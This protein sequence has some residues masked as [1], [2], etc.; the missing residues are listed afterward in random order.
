[1]PYIKDDIGVSPRYVYKLTSRY[2]D[3]ARCTQV[4]NN[5]KRLGIHYEKREFG[6]ICA[7]HFGDSYERHVDSINPLCYT[8]P[9][10]YM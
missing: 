5:L 1:M 10:C 6:S 8:F 2:Y 7:V 9:F 3:P 4:A